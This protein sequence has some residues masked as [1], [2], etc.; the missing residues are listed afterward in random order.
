MDYCG[1]GLV[2]SI[3]DYALQSSGMGDGRTNKEP[4][5]NSDDGYSRVN[6]KL[7]E[8]MSNLIK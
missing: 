2:F 7:I 3:N 5:T 4:I 6:I 8:D 1:A